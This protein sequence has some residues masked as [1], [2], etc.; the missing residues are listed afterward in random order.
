[1]AGELKLRHSPISIVS[2]L[3]RSEDRFAWETLARGYKEFYKTP[4]SDEEYDTAWKRLLQQDAVFGLGAKV[5]GKLVGIAHFLFHTSI[6][7]PKVCYLQDLFTLHEARGRGVARALIQA[8]AQEARK[9]SA[10][11]YYWLTHEDNA[12]ARALYDKV[13]KYNGFIRYDFSL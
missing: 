10:R 4:T 13:G 3:L 11:R 9:H 2:D 8:V 1:M 5:D 7:A 12:V 6:W